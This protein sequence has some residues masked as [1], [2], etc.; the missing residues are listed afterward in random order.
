MQTLSVLVPVRPPLSGIWHVRRG[1]RRTLSDEQV[2]ELR[3]QA[4][5]F[6]TI[7]AASLALA[8]RFGVHPI[9]AREVILRQS[10][11]LVVGEPLAARYWQ[12]YDTDSW[13]T[14]V[15]WLVLLARLSLSQPMVTPVQV[16]MEHRG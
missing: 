3:W 2:R 12:Q 9:T 14:W 1:G 7:Q 8:P 10:H 11:R 4:V 5:E 6:P 15:I 13:L 16:P